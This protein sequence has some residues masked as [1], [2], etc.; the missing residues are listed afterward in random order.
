VGASVPTRLLECFPAP[1]K[2]LA[3]AKQRSARKVGWNMTRRNLSQ[4]TE[5]KSRR[6]A[7]VAWPVNVQRVHIGQGIRLLFSFTD[8]VIAV[9]DTLQIVYPNHDQ[10]QGK[11]AA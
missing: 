11:G 1:L 7:M 9:G 10:R 5:L 2:D 8:D 6:S 4:H 3:E